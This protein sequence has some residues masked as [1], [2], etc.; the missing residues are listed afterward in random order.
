MAWCRHTRENRQLCM[1][2]EWNSEKP[3][4]AGDV[5]A[6]YW[7]KK[8]FYIKRRGEEEQDLPERKSA[9]SRQKVGGGARWRTQSLRGT[10]TYFVWQEPR[11]H[12]WKWWGIGLEGWTSTG[13]WWWLVC[14]GGRGQT[15]FFKTVS[16]LFL[17][18]PSGRNG[19]DGLETRGKKINQENFM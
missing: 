1:K 11:I 6:G 12:V 14:Y 3:Q 4:K 15:F 9:C 8:V 16:I 7:K 13:K 19:E 17:D 2:A 10:V 18:Y 5:S